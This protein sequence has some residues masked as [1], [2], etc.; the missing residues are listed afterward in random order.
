MKKQKYILEPCKCCQEEHDNPD[1][2]IIRNNENGMPEYH[3]FLSQ[4]K[5]EIAKL[6][7]PG[8]KL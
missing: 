4:D 3:L 8:G 2:W 5:I 6:P 1:G 7:L